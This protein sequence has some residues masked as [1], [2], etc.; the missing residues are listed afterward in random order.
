MKQNLQLLL[1]HS[2]EQARPQLAQGK[3]AD[4]IPELSKV[5]PTLLG[6]SVLE[7]GGQEYSAGDAE[8][9]FTL[10]SIE[11]VFA[12]IFALELVGEDRLFELVGMEPS[13][14]PFSELTTLGEFSEKPSN[15][16]INAGA[17]VVSSLLSTLMSF[18]DFLQRVRSF[19]HNPQISCNEEVYR[20][21]Y[22]HSERNHAIAWELKRLKLLV[23]DLDQSLRFYTR[24]CAINV[25]ARDLA[26][27]AA[28]MANGGIDCTTGE[29]VISTSAV[30]ITESLMFTCGL[31]DGS[32]SFA[33]KVGIPAKSGVGGGIMAV[34]N[35]RL[36]IGA[37][38]SALDRYGNSIGATAILEYLSSHCGWHTFRH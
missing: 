20:S 10:Q 12:L 24:S 5:N 13:G 7:L 16:L 32:G 19:C 36:G 6:A 26:R 3:V 37:F 31:Y 14:A 23:G 1:D 4:Y 11:K 34:V 8:V 17:I 28:T 29:R 18:D 35:H 25:C 22:A 2:V 15:P 27:F 30:R 33:V 38:G 21:E 9:Y